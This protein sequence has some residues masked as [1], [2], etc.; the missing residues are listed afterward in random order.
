M[1]ICCS[2]SV[3]QGARVGQGAAYQVP[4]MCLRLPFLCLQALPAYASSLLY[5]GGFLI[6]LDSMPP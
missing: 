2:D 5:F 3:G 6:T 1:H 4:A